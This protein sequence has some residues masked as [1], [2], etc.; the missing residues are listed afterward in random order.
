MRINLPMTFRV[1]FLDMLKLCRATERFNVPVQLPHPF[2]HCGIPGS[3]VP[4]VAFEVLHVDR[5]E[6][7]DCSVETYIRFGDVLAKVVG[8]GILGEMGFDSVESLKKG[9]DVLFVGVL[10]PVSWLIA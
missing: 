1:M 9:L 3:N 2:V 8:G 4:N 6:A 5:V 10:C 7:D